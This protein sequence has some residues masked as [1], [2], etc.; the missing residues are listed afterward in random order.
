MQP[1]Q[2]LSTNKENKNTQYWKQKLGIHNNS[3][4][5]HTRAFNTN[6]TQKKLTFPD[7]RKN[8]KSTRPK[9]NGQQKGQVNNLR[10]II[11][12][13]GAQQLQK[14]YNYMPTTQLHKVSIR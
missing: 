7:H 9:S 5:P 2:Q 4:L 1:T 14:A 13:I 3:V 8:L 6:K 11:K 12:L 10:I